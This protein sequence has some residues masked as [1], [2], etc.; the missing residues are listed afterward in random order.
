MTARRLILILAILVTTVVVPAQAQQ[1]LRSPDVIFVP[2][3]QEV[4]DAM[5]KLAKVTKNDVIYDLGSGD[6]RIPITAAK[7]YGARGVGIDIDP[8][9]IKEATE[10]LKTAG[11]GDRV[12]FLNQDLF[13]T[14][15]SEATVVTLYLLP[16]LNVKLIPK[17]NKELKPGTRIVSHAF[18]MSSDGTERKPR[19][20][21]NVNGRTVYF[22][23]IP[24]Q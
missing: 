21:L 11:V 7:T 22:W 8:Q 5:L 20:T 19:E 16:S 15:I 6:G 1:P 17:L 10:N 2:T 18:D 4:V 9:R 14:D 12:K 23:T 13:T 3:P 24:I